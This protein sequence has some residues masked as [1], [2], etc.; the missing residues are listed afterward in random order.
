MPLSFK[1]FV[2]KTNGLNLIKSPFKRFWDI[3]G[4][5]DPLESRKIGIHHFYGLWSPN[6]QHKIRK[7]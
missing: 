3:L 2:A 4:P 6:L 7:Y 5:L 1:P